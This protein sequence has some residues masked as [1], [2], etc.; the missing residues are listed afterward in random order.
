[1]CQPGYIG[2]LQM[3]WHNSVVGVGGYYY[4]AAC[5]LLGAFPLSHPWPPVRAVTAK[6]DWWVIGICCC[7]GDRHIADYKSNTS[8]RFLNTLCFCEPQPKLCFPATWLNRGAWEGEE[9]VAWSEEEAYWLWEAKNGRV[10]SIVHCHS[11]QWNV[12]NVALPEVTATWLGFYT[13]V[14]P[15]RFL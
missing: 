12:Y 2:G 4:T 6:G 8:T 14:R 5:H 7:L 15:M 13:C 10:V 11:N 9:L 3:C 1:M